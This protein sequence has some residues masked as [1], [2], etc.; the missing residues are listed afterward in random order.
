MVIVD[1]LT[2][3]RRME[4]E[5]LYAPPFADTDRNGV[6]D[7]FEASEVTQI[8]WTIDAYIPRLGD[9]SSG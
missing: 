4:P 1:H 5:L 9:V 6:C 2:A 3:T 8:I 7:I